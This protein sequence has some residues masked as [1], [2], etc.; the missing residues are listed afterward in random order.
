M[1]VQTTAERQQVLE[2]VDRIPNEFL[3]S[4]LKLVQAF[5]E[6]VVLPTAEDS[7]RQ[8]WQETQ[9]GETRPLSE[10]WDGIDAK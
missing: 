1:T 4:F 6:S 3:P 9:R 2:E 10:L 5:R 7:F 8:A